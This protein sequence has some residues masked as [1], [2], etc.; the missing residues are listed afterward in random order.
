MDWQP[1]CMRRLL[2]AGASLEQLDKSGRSALDVACRCGF[3]D[4][5]LALLGHPELHRASVVR[6]LRTAE[7]SKESDCSLLLRKALE[8]WRAEQVE[9]VQGPSL[10]IA[11]SGDDDD[12]APEWQSMSRALV[13]QLKNEWSVAMAEAQRALDM[14]GGGHVSDLLAPMPRT[15]EAR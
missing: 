3:S 13:A 15:G 10:A 12:D 1:E 14:F 9:G 11:I 4:C 5:V 6:A 8:L 2:E 7:R